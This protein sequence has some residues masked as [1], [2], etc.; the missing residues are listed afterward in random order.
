MRPYFIGFFALTIISP[1]GCEAKKPT[2]EEEPPRQPITFQ[3]GPGAAPGVMNMLPL[4]DR[5]V[6]SNE[7]KGIWMTAMAD[8]TV[9]P[10]TSLEQFTELRKESARLYNAVKEGHYVVCW[11]ASR[12]NGKAVFAYWKG[13]PEK[14][15]PV[16]LADG[17]VVENMSA[18][19]FKNTPKA[20]VVEAAAPPK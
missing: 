17:T 12:A 20:G 6:A 14:G 16:V 7:L 4:V 19:D 8:T 5:T 2:R 15:G 1:F 11:R 3:P 13:V 18:Q 10:P 9:P